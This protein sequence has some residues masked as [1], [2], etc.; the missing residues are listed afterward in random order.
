MIST[1]DDFESRCLEIQIDTKKVVLAKCDQYNT[2]QMW[3]FS[4][5]GNKER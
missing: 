1:D 4:E 2:Y 5:Y 3:K